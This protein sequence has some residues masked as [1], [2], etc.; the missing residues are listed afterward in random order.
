MKPNLL[1]HDEQITT[2]L[3]KMLVVTAFVSDN[4]AA[5]WMLFPSVLKVIFLSFAEK[6]ATAAI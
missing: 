6:T 1:F 3:Q 4:I 5:C 2:S